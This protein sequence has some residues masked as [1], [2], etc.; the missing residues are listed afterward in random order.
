MISVQI[1]GTLLPGLQ[2]ST[3]GEDCP[4]RPTP[5]PGPQALAAAMPIL[6]VPSGWGFHRPSTSLSCPQPCSLAVV[7]GCP[8][9]SP[10]RVRKETLCVKVLLPGFLILP[11]KP[12][13]THR[14]ILGLA[15]FTVQQV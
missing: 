3:Q 4:H 12:V 14:I 2:E 1:S 15:L 6:N 8:S 7:P 9:W 10:E 11:P 5:R 13:L